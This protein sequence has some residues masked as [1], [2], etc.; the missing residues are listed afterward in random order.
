[1]TR[2]R[3]VAGAALALTAAL[4]APFAFGGSA[5]QGG[6]GDP[7][8]SAVGGAGDGIADYTPLTPTVTGT[9]GTPD[10]TVVDVSWTNSDNGTLGVVTEYEVERETPSGAE[11]WTSAGTVD[12]D[13][14]AL[15]DTELSP[16]TQYRHR[17]RGVNSTIFGA[18]GTGNAVTTA[19]LPP[20]IPRQYLGDDLVWHLDL[21][22]ADA[23]T[24]SG[25]S[26]LGATDLGSL[27]Y[28]FTLATGTVE[29]VATIGTESFGGSLFDGSTLTSGTVLFGD[30]QNTDFTL[31]V[32]CYVQTA[33]IN[34]AFFSHTSGT[35]T[36]FHKW[37]SDEAEWSYN[38]VSVSTTNSFTAPKVVYYRFS[39]NDLNPSDDQQKLALDDGA[40]RSVNGTN[41]PTDVTDWVIGTQL[42]GEYVCE[43]VLSLGIAS[44]TVEGS[45]DLYFSDK[46]GF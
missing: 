21:G 24:L 30:L 17:V 15:S 27:G 9:L 25:T 37:K 29:F 35:N 10:T 38:A 46:Y 26:V 2:T 44:A 11:N 36:L 33:S 20:S 34:E 12:G 18:Y 3:S 43:A 13:T 28:D 23:L 31:W 4:L 16:D 32:V 7:Q 40:I 5:P 42:T 41:M 8:D 22:D 6:A 1:M 45:M 19:A 39:Q 14:F